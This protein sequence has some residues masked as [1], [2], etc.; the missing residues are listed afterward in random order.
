MNFEPGLAERHKSLRSC[1]AACVYQRGLENV[2]MDLDKAPGNLS[3][4]L[5]GHE[6]RHFSVDNL[7]R[8]IQTSGDLTP[9]WYLVEKYLS[10][11]DAKRAAMM[12]RL[13]ALTEVLTQV[14]VQSGLVVEKPKGRT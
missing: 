1:I 12:T 2:A 10:D 4:E 6:K 13:V 11:P 14:A 8:Y 9:V 5:G 7:E 3:V